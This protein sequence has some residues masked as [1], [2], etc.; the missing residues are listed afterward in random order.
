MTLDIYGHLFADLE[1]AHTRF[2]ASE[3]ALLGC[4]R[5][6]QG[7]PVLQQQADIEMKTLAK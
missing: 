3:N 5:L 6:Q 2:A 4:Q 1:D 7:S